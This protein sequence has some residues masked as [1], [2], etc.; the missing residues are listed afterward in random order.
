MPDQVCWGAVQG[1]YCC[2]RWPPGLSAWSWFFRAS[3]LVSSIYWLVEAMGVIS[4][5]RTSSRHVLKLKLTMHKAC[6]NLHNRYHLMPSL[7]MVLL[8]FWCQHVSAQ[9]TY[10]WLSLLQFTSKRKWPD[11]TYA[12][13]HSQMYRIHD[14][15]IHTYIHS[16]IHTYIHKWASARLTLFILGLAQIAYWRASDCTEQHNGGSANT[17]QCFR[18][19]CCWCRCLM[20]CAV[21]SYT[22]CHMPCLSSPVMR[23]ILIYYVSHV[24]SNLSCHVHLP[25]LVSDVMCHVTPN[26][27]ITALFSFLFPSLVSFSC[28]SHNLP[29]GCAGCNNHGPIQRGQESNLQISKTLTTRNSRCHSFCSIVSMCQHGGSHWSNVYS[30]CCQA[31][32]MLLNLQDELIKLDSVVVQVC[33]HFLYV[34]VYVVCM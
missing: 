12:E 19:H 8:C 5:V 4:L 26:H 2:N 17:C 9:V 32:N 29:G 6:P 7:I 31:T 10:C 1:R 3:S 14:P 18:D 33:L 28:V 30:L 20:S 23:H 22:I 13:G 25:C 11:M 27:S 34:C 15:L 16:D 24:M 21:S